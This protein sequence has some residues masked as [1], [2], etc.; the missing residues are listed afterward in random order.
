MSARPAHVGMIGPWLL[1]RWR[2]DGA[3][4][5]ARRPADRRHE[6]VTAEIDATGDMEILIDGI[7]SACI[8]REV[9]IALIAD[10]VDRGVLVVP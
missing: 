1:E 8:P 5:E 7:A 3:P 10:A 6:E 9:L 2:Y 4:L